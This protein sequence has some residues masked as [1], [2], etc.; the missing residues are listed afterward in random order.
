MRGKSPAPAGGYARAGVRWRA[1]VAAL[2]AQRINFSLCSATAACSLALV[3]P[4]IA[5][6]AETAKRDR[7]GDVEAVAPRPAARALDIV[8]IR[9]R[10]SSLGIAVSVEL[11]GNFERVMRARRMRGAAAAIVL[12]RRRGKPRV[13]ATVGSGRR[14]KTLASIGR[15]REAA[16]VRRGRV[17][18]FYVDRLDAGKLRGVTVKTFAP[19][20][21]RGSAAVTPT[22]KRLRKLMK[23]VA[24]DAGA[25][26]LDAGG[27]PCPQIDD[28]SAVLSDQI[29]GIEADADKARGGERDELE[30]ALREARML[31]ERLLDVLSSPRCE[32]VDPDDA[33][34][35]GEGEDFL[36]PDE[37]GPLPA[38]FTYSPS[39]PRD[40]DAVTFTASAVGGSFDWSWGDGTSSLGS[41]APVATH[42]Y[43]DPGL[44]T[45]QLSVDSGAASGTRAVEVGCAPGARIVTRDGRDQ[46]RFCGAFGQAFASIRFEPVASS[47]TF[48]G[49]QTVY[50]IAPGS[51]CEVHANS[52]RLTCQATAADENPAHEWGGTFS[53]S[54]EAATGMQIKATG[55]DS[56]GNPI[57]GLTTT[58]TV[59]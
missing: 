46:I 45:V 19:P 53:I 41:S 32:E 58:L 26:K 36:D 49:A 51:T 3:V 20:R 31:Y 6:A 44:Y 25:V 29:E 8:E 18:T 5:T 16:V 54:P 35:F 24:A 34:D 48:D 23:R 39:A 13:V 40:G 57:P 1:G 10:A 56:D 30:A 9:T 11:R 21:R 4:S 55:L 42:A 52:R 59:G 14:R 37:P 33:E 22:A 7:S 50:E 38:S 28:L 15:G 12:R 17:L 2:R 27:S 47:F 43:A